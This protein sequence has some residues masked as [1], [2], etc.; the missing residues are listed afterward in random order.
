LGGL[1]TTEK[2]EITEITEKIQRLKGS[3]KVGS[4]RRVKIAVWK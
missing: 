1:K 4:Y 2:T 3:K